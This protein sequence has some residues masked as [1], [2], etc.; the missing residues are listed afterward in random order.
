MI[1]FEVLFHLLSR[2]KALN[3]NININI[4]NIMETTNADLILMGIF[5]AGMIIM[6]VSLLFL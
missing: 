1:V 6:V 4:N 5:G 2:P 3:T